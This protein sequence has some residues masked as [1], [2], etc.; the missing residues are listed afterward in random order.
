M[1]YAER[2]ERKKG[3]RYR[4]ICKAA[5]GRYRSAGTFSTKKRALEVAQEAER[6]A[7]EVAGGAP[8]LLSP[9]VFI[10]GA[11]RGRQGRKPEPAVRD[12]QVASLAGR[13]RPQARR[14][15]VGPACFQ[16]AGAGKGAGDLDAG[17]V[18]PADAA[19]AGP[20]LRQRRCGDRPG[21]AAL[22]PG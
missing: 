11:D 16:P 2:R 13:N 7:A 12:P 9:S 5:D 21:G 4:G 6:H 22:Q 3:V 15:A 17:D 18:G 1:A 14:A 10:G 20:G 8:G 19:D